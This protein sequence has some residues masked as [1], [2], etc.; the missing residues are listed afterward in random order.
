MSD[1]EPNPSVVS[2][3]V[4]STVRCGRCVPLEPWLRG[5]FLF[6]FVSISVSSLNYIILCIWH[7]VVLEIIVIA[8]FWL[9]LCAIPGMGRHQF[10]GTVAGGQDRETSRLSP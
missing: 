4:S 2:V 5:A 10:R 6:Y 1:Q 8:L 7:M 3:D 9:T